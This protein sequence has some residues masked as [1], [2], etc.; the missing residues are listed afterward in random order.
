MLR[1]IH[2][3]DIHFSGK[4]EYAIKRMR[5]TILEKIEQISQKK[6]FNMIFI[7][8]DLAYQGGSYDQ[9][10]IAFI[11]SLIKVLKLSSDDLFMIP[12]NH[13]VCRSQMRT[14]IIEGTRK[15]NFKF[16]KDTIMQLQK[17]FREYKEF[18]KNLK[19]ENADYI[20]KIIKKGNYNVFLMN[21]TF[22]AG[23]NNDEGNLVLE[24]DCFYD[25][26][27]SLKDQEDCVNIAIGHHP[28]LHFVRA[29]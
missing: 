18:Y 13:D 27:K 9:S 1:W 7:T 4:E 14:L 20:Y 2:L 11:K 12:G 3:S 28:I 6:D 17:D 23:T 24:R 16:E 25:T 21:T 8:G 19:G 29:D 22:T 5:D 26:I 15:D 10:L